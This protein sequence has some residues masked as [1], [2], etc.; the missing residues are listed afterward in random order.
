[1]E[2]NSQV[3]Q[4]HTQLALSLLDS[5]ESRRDD[6]EARATFQ[7]LIAKSA[8]IQP[9][10]LL[11]RL[12]KAADMLEEKAILY[13]KAGDHTKALKTLIVAAKD[14][15]A[16][17]RY[18]DQMS[19]DKAEAFRANLLTQ[20][21]KVCLEEGDAQ[22]QA[23]ARDLFNRRGWQM[24]AVEALVFLPDCWSVASVSAGLTGVVAHSGQKMRSAM[25]MA[26]LS[27][28]DNLN[29]KEEL[30]RAQSQSFT[31]RPSR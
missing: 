6:I 3:E 24:N 7:T 5:I 19:A 12:E 22:L 11:S 30:I 4:F 23:A 29:A 16:A 1:M 18:C 9:A 17:E 15:Q 13:G 31:L 10:F 27:K 8:L 28:A 25:I 14:P 21:L 2:E 26:S 20:A